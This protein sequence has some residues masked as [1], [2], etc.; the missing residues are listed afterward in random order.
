M[1]PRRRRLRDVVDAFGPGVLAP[2]GGVDRKR[3]GG[4]DLRRPGGARALERHRPPPGPGGGGPPRRAPARPPGRESWSRTPRSS[5]RPACTCGST[6]SW[7]CT[8]RPPSR[9]GGSMQR[10]GIDEAAARARVDAQMPLDGEAAV[11]AHRGGRLGQPRRHGP[12]RGP[13]GLRAAAAGPRLSRPRRDP[14]RAAPGR[15][16]H[17][18]PPRPARPRAR[19]GPARH[20]RRGRPGDGAHRAPAGAARGSALVPGGRP[21]RGRRGPRPSRRPS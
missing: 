6:A 10:D 17:R 3:A 18:P 5:W 2:D 9:C 20:R 7:S 8:A 16:G 1:A 14:A 21:G 4:R 15:D 12:G 19:A 11:R 13:P